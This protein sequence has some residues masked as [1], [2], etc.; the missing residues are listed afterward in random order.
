MNEELGVPKT[1]FELLKS[2]WRS[3]GWELK[4]SYLLELKHGLMGF[5]PAIFSADDRRIIVTSDLHLLE[6]VWQLLDPREATLREDVAYVNEAKGIA[7]YETSQPE[8][9]EDRKP[10]QMLTVTEFERLVAGEE[11][12]KPFRWAFGLMGGN[13]PSQEWFF[14]SLTEQ[15]SKFDS[16]FSNLA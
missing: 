11:E 1:L 13:R 9:R 6:R 10:I 7:Y 12:E 16:T 15:A 8:E 3:A 14:K 5:F 2:D 4:K